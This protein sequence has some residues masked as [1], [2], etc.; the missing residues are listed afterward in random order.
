MRRGGEHVA[1]ALICQECGVYVASVTE[2][3]PSA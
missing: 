3:H 1:D 2:A